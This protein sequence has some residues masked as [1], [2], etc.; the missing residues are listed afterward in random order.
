MASVELKVG[1][2]VSACM[3]GALLDFAQQ[4]FD[5]YGVKINSVNFEWSP[6]GFG[7]QAKLMEVSEDTFASRATLK[8]HA[9]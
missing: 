7:G 1:V 3:H 4:M 6:L 2:D 8:K 5:E 9:E